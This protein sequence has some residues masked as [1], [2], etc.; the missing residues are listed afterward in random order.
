VAV[1]AIVATTVTFAGADVKADKDPNF[2]FTKLKTFGWKTPPGDVK[3]WVTQNSNARAEPA[4]R[5]YEPALMQAVENEFTKR[6]YPPSAGAAPDFE[7]AYYVLI[8]AGMSSQQAGQF[9]PTNAQWG[10]PMF[11]PATTSLDVYP[12]G[13]IVL[14]ASVPAGGA[15]IWRGIVQSRVVEGPISESERTKRIQGFMKQL[16]AKFPERKTKK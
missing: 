8:T 10:I 4:R 15:I 14:D 11:A 1:L 12:Q 3:I 13:S 16:V 9:L 2:D 7:L 5:T 6:G